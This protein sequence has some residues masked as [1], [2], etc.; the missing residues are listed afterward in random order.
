MLICL[1][2]DIFYLYAR[3]TFSKWFGV[4]EISTS[5]TG[6]VVTSSSFRYELEEN[7]K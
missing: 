2:T 3:F 4:M 6:N 7:A 1:Y 5:S